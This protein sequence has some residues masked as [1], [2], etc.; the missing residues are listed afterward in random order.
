M[1]APIGVRAILACAA[2][3]MLVQGVE[4]AGTAVEAGAKGTRIPASSAAP[5]SPVPRA[6][7]AQLRQYKRAASALTVRER[8]RVAA[9]H[10]CGW[11]CGR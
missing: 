1:C 6:L 4:R 10:H 9:R 5:S 8:R 7:R 11:Q 2:Q 3:D